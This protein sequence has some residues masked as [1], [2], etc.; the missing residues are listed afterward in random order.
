MSVELLLLVLPGGAEI[1]LQMGVLLQLRIAVGRQHLAVGVD[2]DALSLRSAPAAVSG[3]SRSWP[4]TTMN[5]PFSTVRDTGVGAGVPKVSVLAR[6][7]SAMQS[8]LTSPT[9]NTMG[10]KLLHAPVLSRWRTVPCRKSALTWLVG[11][12]QRQRRGR[13]RPPCPGCRTESAT[14]G[15]GRPH[16]SFHSRSMS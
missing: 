8:R 2:V 10:S 1:A 5:G 6:S 3:R 11:I 15:S 13:H 14:S 7:S 9:S 12:A 16:P 4:E